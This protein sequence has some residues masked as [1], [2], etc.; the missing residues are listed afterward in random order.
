M[1]RQNR[2]T[3]EPTE[4]RGV[5]FRREHDVFSGSFLFERPEDYSLEHKDRDMVLLWMT[6]RV[7]TFYLKKTFLEDKYL[8]PEN[9]HLGPFACTWRLNFGLAAEPQVGRT[10]ST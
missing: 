7:S 5:L 1:N 9:M 3:E 4:P 2:R 6:Q 8:N 10:I